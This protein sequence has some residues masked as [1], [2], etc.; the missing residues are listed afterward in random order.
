MEKWMD[1]WI[2]L[3]LLNKL[4]T[5]VVWCVLHVGLL[6]AVTKEETV[7]KRAMSECIIT[8]LQV[9]SLKN[10]DALILICVKLYSVELYSLLVCL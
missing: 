3:M 4:G 1:G 2:I 7:S 5:K 9:M 10:I 8:F 6:F